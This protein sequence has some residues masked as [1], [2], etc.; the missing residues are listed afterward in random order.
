M[1]LLDQFVTFDHGYG[2]PSPA[3]SGFDPTMAGIG[4][5]GLAGTFG[6]PK[7]STNIADVTGPDNTGF[8]NALQ[9][10]ML[11]NQY[12]RTNLLAQQQAQE[13]QLRK[14]QIEKA[15]RDAETQ[16]ELQAAVGGYYAANPAQM[17]MT[18]AAGLP[19]LPDAPNAVPA[20]VPGTGATAEGL[21]K[22]QPFQAA[23]IKANPLGAAQMFMK[24]TSPLITKEGDFARNRET[25]QLLWQ[26]PK[27]P[28]TNL[29]KLQAELD[30]MPAD[31][32]RRR[33]WQSMIQKESERDPWVIGQ[34][35]TPNGPAMV[36]VPRPSV[37]GVPGGIQMSGPGN[38]TTGTGLA[39]A[40]GVKVLA[41]GQTPTF[42]D[43]Q[44]EKFRAA[45]Q[46]RTQFKTAT[47][48]FENAL[49]EGGGTGLNTWINNPTDPK[50]IRINTAYNNMLSLL[51]GESLYNT[52]VLQQG[53]LTWLNSIMLN[54]QSLR[55]ALA[56][57]DSFFAQM[58]DMRKL[59]D[60]NYEALRSS[61]ANSAQ[62]VRGMREGVVPP[63]EKKSEPIN[64]A[65]QTVP[66][67][68]LPPPEKNPAAIKIFDD[69]KKARI[70]RAQADSAM[71]ALGYTD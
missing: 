25:G 47:I 39:S 71:R 28:Q 8:N 54:P 66:N 43:A 67:T 51:R 48:E 52:G 2:M 4:L 20:P 24:D 41:Q 69:L 53:E 49:K 15:A 1:G 23:A 31:D 34:V 38:P 62:T 60:N 37:P 61:F 10:G 29:G 18:N 50:A 64:R 44:L 17:T 70:T 35:Q 36:A 40:P 6:R 30:A 56:S 13:A 16:K 45:D 63:A 21:M 12:R 32:P 65:A 9:M 5:L 58:K 57:P 11:S 33:T 55:G 46:A 68:A 26:N 7:Y 14:L 42:T 3:G 19:T 22:Y 27:G 59:A